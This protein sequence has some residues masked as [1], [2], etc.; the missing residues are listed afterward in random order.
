MPLHILLAVLFLLSLPFS[1]TQA[2]AQ[3]TP[4]QPG[5]VKIDRILT[6]EIGGIRQVVEIKT[7]D[8][9]KPGSY[10]EGQEAQ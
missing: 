3:E 8:T 10:Q 9:T 7:D 2:Q 1:A 4:L 6:P 5:P